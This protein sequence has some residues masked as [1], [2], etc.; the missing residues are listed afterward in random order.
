MLFFVLF[1]GTSN[2][3]LVNTVYDAASQMK[4]L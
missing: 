4:G 1:S 3:N 2:V